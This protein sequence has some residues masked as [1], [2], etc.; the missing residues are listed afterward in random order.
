MIEDLIPLILF[1]MYLQSNVFIFGMLKTYIRTPRVY[2]GFNKRI[3][4]GELF[5]LAMPLIGCI[6]SWLI[7]LTMLHLISFDFINLILSN[8][9]DFSLM[10]L[11]I[12]L[13]VYVWLSDSTPS[14]VAQLSE[15]TLNQNTWLYKCMLVYPF[16]L[17]GVS[18][19]WINSHFRSLD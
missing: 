4:I 1:L 6:C 17:Q 8:L 7:L 19:N 15:Q 16:I 18:I 3:S 11:N 9:Y 10:L 14:I 12:P 2:A 13:G 5:N